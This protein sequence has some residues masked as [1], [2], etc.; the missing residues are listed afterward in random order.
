MFTYPSNTI[1]I[2]LTILPDTLLKILH[3]LIYLQA[4]HPGQLLM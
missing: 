4:D 3:D 1:C 2:H